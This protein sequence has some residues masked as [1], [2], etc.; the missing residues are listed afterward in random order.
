EQVSKLNHAIAATKTLVNSH[1]PSLLV[2][3]PASPRPVQGGLD[4]RQ[5]A[6]AWSKDS[7]EAAVRTPDIA[8][9]HPM[10]CTVDGTAKVEFHVP[11]NAS[12]FR[13][14]VHGHTASGRLGVV[15]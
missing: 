8:L 12:H 9:W 1:G 10:L 2:M 6:S 4:V 15:E 3:L 7:Q 11:G 14:L 13:I 5:Y